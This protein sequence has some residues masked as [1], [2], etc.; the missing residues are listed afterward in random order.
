MRAAAV[1]LLPDPLAVVLVVSPLVLWVEL[2]EE[3]PLVVLL[4][5]L[6]W[7]VLVLLVVFVLVLELPPEVPDVPPA[8]AGF[9]PFRKAKGS[10]L[11][12]AA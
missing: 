2:V 6:P 1:C 12:Y 3:A 8:D 9:K 7:V 5:P 10:L 4:L 11:V